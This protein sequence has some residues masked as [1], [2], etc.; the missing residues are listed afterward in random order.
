MENKYRDWDK[1]K[2]QI[3]EEWEK[4][5]NKIDKALH[6]EVEVLI[7]ENPPLFP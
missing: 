1:E 3:I 7:E 2:D 5:A 4:E 6:K